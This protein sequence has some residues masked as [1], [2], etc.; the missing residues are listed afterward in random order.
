M[1]TGW[2]V[3]DCLTCIPGTKTIWHD[4][5][6]NIPGLIDMCD[7][8]DQWAALI[9]KI[10]VAS[11]IAPPDYI[12]RNASY[13]PA[14]NTPGVKTVSLVQDIMHEGDFDIQKDV[15]DKSSVVV[16][17]SPYTKEY[18]P[19]TNTKSVIIPLGTDFDLFRPID[20]KCEL[21]EKWG[22]KSESI[23]FVGSA[24][25]IKGYDILEDLIKCSPDHNFVLVLK[26]EMT[27]TLPPN[28]KIFNLVTHEALTE[29]INA[30]DLLVCTSRIETLH[31][32][33]IEAA[34]CNLPL[35]VSD[36]G[37]YFGNLMVTPFGYL[38]RDGN[39][40]HGIDHVL[41]SLY[42]Y[43]PRQWFLDNGYDKQTCMNRWK[44]LVEN[45]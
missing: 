30:C 14:L 44:E 22:I 29:I 32:A 20:K 41:S 21:Q 10:N 35:V 9:G 36:V 40:R 45:L 27:P 5:L 1:K 42:K 34:A 4:L 16:F 37:A 23:L 26:D 8:R 3:N 15:C 17:N 18:A 33:G 24:S 39:F 11:S 31:L 2:L 13:F 25:W 38:V 12:I 43:S 6:E 7:A 19:K 28:C